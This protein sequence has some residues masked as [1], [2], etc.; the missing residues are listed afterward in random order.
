M[1]NSSDE[2]EVDQDA[3]NKFLIETQSNIWAGDNVAAAAKNRPTMLPSLKMHK[4]TKHLALRK[5][6]TFQK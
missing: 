6:T 5:K 1:E 2:M 4:N 3:H